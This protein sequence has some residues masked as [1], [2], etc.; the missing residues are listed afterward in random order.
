MAKKG[1]KKTVGRTRGKQEA[2]KYIMKLHYVLKPNG[3]YAPRY[4][5]V[6]L[7]ETEEES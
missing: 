3:A 6:Y 2:P 4:E 7:G 1:A 5:R